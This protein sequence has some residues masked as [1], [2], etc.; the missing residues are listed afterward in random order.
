MN[1]ERSNIAE[2]TK[3]PDNSGEDLQLLEALKAIEQ[4]KDNPDLQQWAQKGFNFGYYNTSDIQRPRFLQQEYKNFQTATHER[5]HETVARALGWNVTKVSIIPEGNVLGFT[6]A[7]PNP[8]KSFATLLLDKIAICFAGMAAEEAL[9]N[10]DHR[11]C[12]SDFAQANYFAEILARMSGQD[13][14]AMGSILSYGRRIART[15]MAD[16]GANN[17]QHQAFTLTKNTVA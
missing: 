6:M 14:S 4:L 11:G 17:L 3:L 8:N 12:G 1:A 16:S 15:I 13:R 5:G 7:L 2:I 10:H 9:G